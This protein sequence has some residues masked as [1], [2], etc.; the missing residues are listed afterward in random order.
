MLKQVYMV[1]L[2][3]HDHHSES[4]C[5][6]SEEQTPLLTSKLKIAKFFEQE[7]IKINE[8]ILEQSFS[9]KPNGKNSELNKI[10][11][12][13]FFLQKD[14]HEILHDIALC[15]IQN[16]YNSNLIDI[17][18]FDKFSDKFSEPSE[19]IFNI[20]VHYNFFSQNILDFGVSN[21]LNPGFF[22][23][24]L[25]ILDFCYYD[26]KISF[27]TEIFESQKYDCLEKM[28]WVNLLI[29]N[30]KPSKN[31]CDSIKQTKKSIMRKFLRKK[32]QAV[33]Y[34]IFCQNESKSTT[35]KEFIEERCLFCLKNCLGK[36]PKMMT[37]SNLFSEGFF[38][39]ILSENLFNFFN[40][41]LIKKKIKTYLL[42]ASAWD[43]IFLF[44]ESHENFIQGI[45]MLCEIKKL[46]KLCLKQHLQLISF[47]ERLISNEK[48][49]YLLTC[50]NSI[51]L[52]VKLANFTFQ[53]SKM[54][55]PFLKLYSKFANFFK[56]CAFEMF[57]SLISN[58]KECEI[59]LFK[60]CFPS[61]NNLIDILFAEKDFF[62]EILSQK[63]VLKA[64][65]NSLVPKYKYDY[66]ILAASSSFLQLK[67]CFFID[68]ESEAKFENKIIDKNHGSSF[69]SFFS[70]SEKF[71]DERF[72]KLIN[73]FAVMKKASLETTAKNNHIYQFAIFLHA[74]KFRCFLDL[75]F[76]IGA[77]VFIFYRLAIFNLISVDFYLVTSY[78]E[79]MTR[80]YV[81]SPNYFNSPTQTY[82]VS[83]I[84]SKLN[85]F[86]DPEN[87]Q[88]I[89]QLFFIY[90]QPNFDI[91]NFINDNLNMCQFF[92][93]GIENYANQEQSYRIAAILSL[94]IGLKFILNIIF[95]KQVNKKVLVNKELVFD[96]LIT[97]FSGLLLF[98]KENFWNFP[99]SSYSIIV[100]FNRICC[101]FIIFLLGIRFL[102]YFELVHSISV[103]IKIIKNMVS[104]L[105][106]F[107]A[108]LLFVLVGFAVI[109]YSFFNK[110]ASDD[111]ANQ[112]FLETIFYLLGASFGNF[113]LSVAEPYSLGYSIIL[114]IYM[115]LVT[116]I[117]F[118]LLIAILSNTY[119][120]MIERGT[121]EYGHILYAAK[122]LK[123]YNKNYGALVIFPY[124][125][126]FFIYPLIFNYMRRGNLTCNLL[127]TE[128]GYFLILL[129]FTSVFILCNIVL[130]PISWIKICLQ[131]IL[132]KYR[133]NKNE[134]KPKLIIIIIHFIL[135]NIFG[136]LF[137]VCLL[138]IND[139][140]CFFKSAYKFC[141][142]KYENLL[143]EDYFFHSF[144]DLIEDLHQKQTKKLTYDQF[145]DEFSRKVEKNKG[146]M[147]LNWFFK[148]DLLCKFFGGHQP[149][150][151]NYLK[152][153]VVEEF[154][155]IS[156]LK[157][158]VDNLKTTGVIMKKKKFLILLNILNLAKG[159]LIIEEK[160]K[161]FKEI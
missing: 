12:F 97:F 61:S 96:L 88:C 73:I 23:I 17:N 140:P 125:I 139:I 13:L 91:Y 85:P 79:L 76:F 18:I 117:L 145:Y 60:V 25:P 159:S 146:N 87:A 2:L 55:S 123:K 137:L 14:K 86:N 22:E 113:S 150:I 57:S 30:S 158:I 48:K 66:N 93:K 134:K 27:Y 157:I 81:L 107:F 56:E 20:L 28:K 154:I 58:V 77:F 116:I 135:W 144:I 26:L 148:N 8:A 129:I 95:Q 71:K 10:S 1:S 108:I 75:V 132:M 80:N 29:Q 130:I 34:S 7:Q 67:S 122:N 19:L 15:L 9:E 38:S 94:L 72:L 37:R 64:I 63:I 4:N 40:R 11:F 110:T 119:A 100:V 103:R 53:L 147:R 111:F 32:F 105:M 118:N 6:S 104:D 68:F 70:L 151:K 51:L 46:Q 33:Q 114:V 47:I 161:N 54:N 141:H 35:I 45:F 127:V 133:L 89:S 16:K 101:T 98:L 142:N 36:I 42:S 39:K 102:T 59:V 156:L 138:I 44:L 136:I 90:N 3:N 126:N 82:V 131:I 24:I 83:D 106:S 115:F 149:E 41:L 78:F 69:L 120:K 62:I 124:P 128:I 31:M 52:L 50:A 49:K 153:L 152:K 43:Q 84:M 5:M 65:E 21:S 109:M 121:M 160:I 143:F 74:I 99:V 92:K 112:N 155:D